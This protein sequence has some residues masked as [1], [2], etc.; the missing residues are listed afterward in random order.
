VVSRA[1]PAFHNQIDFMSTFFLILNRF[2]PVRL[3]DAILLHHM[4]IK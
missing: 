4:D 1:R 3:R 2:L